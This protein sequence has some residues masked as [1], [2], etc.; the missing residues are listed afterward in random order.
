MNS[1]FNK[2]QSLKYISA[3]LL[4]F[5]FTLGI[6]PRKTLHDWFAN[7]KDSTSSIPASNTEKLSKAGF[8]CKCDDLVAESHF[9]TFSSFIVVN[10]QSFNSFFSF[11]IPSL[12]SLS[13]FHNNLRGP[14]FKI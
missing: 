14:P 8:N 9:V 10:F 4:L 13:L 5:V 2:S 11:N 3:S 1:F 7:H 12:V 6:T